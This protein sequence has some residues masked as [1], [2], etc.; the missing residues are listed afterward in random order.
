MA[1]TAQASVGISSAS[2]TDLA[3]IR[4]RTEALAS[5]KLPFGLDTETGYHGEDREGA[6]LHPEENF[7]V[8][9]QLTNDLSWAR[10]I[11]L[12]FDTGVN[13]D[14][15]AAAA[16]LWPLFHAI[17]DEGLP[18]AVAHG[19]QAELRWMSRWF[20]RNLWDHPLFGRQVIAAR[21]YYPVRSCTLL[22]SFTEGVNKSQALKSLTL[23]CYGYQMRELSDL[24]AAM[25]GRPPTDKEKKSVRFNVFDPS[26]PEVVAYAC[27]DAVFTLR[28]HKDRWPKVRNTFAYKVEMAVLP[29]VCDTADTGITYDWNMLR[30]AAAEIREFAG[31][32]LAEVVE[33][34][35]ALAGEKLP[36][37]FN[38]GSSMQLCDLFYEKCKLPVYHWTD[39]GKS[40][41]KKPSIDAKKALPRL[42]AEVPEVAKYHEW[43]RLNT[44]HDNFLSIYEAKYSWSADGKAHPLLVQH[45]TIAGR[46]SCENPNAQQPPGKYHVTLRDGTEFRFN[47]RDAI[48]ASPAG[49]R[50]W[51]ELVLIDAGWQ[52]PED[53][54]E[55]GWYIEG[56]DY[57]QIELRVLAAEA[58]E[59]ALLEAFERGEDVHRLT[60][61][62]MLGIPLAEV[63]DE[64][65]QDPGKRMNFAIGYGLSPH[66]LAQ[67]TGMS[68]AAA[69]EKFAAFHAAYPHLKPFTRRVVTR[70]RRDGCVRT[71]F[72]RLVTLHD[73]RNENPRVRSAEERTAGNCVIQGPATGDYVKMA[74]VRAVRALKAAGLADKVRLI[75][76]IHDA[77]EF[78]VRRD[79]APADVI[80]VLEPAVIFPI[81]GPGVPWPP[82]VADWHIGESWGQKRE[83]HMEAGAVVLGKREKCERCAAP[84]PVPVPAPE[85][86]SP[87]ASVPPAAPAPEPVPADPDAPPRRVIVETREMPTVDQVARLAEF[88]RSLPGPNSVELQVPDAV[89]Q[90]GFP[91]GLT[92]AH[93]AQVAVILGSSVV[94]YDLDSVD[95]GALVAGLAL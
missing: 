95:A 74:M 71:K 25:L 12:G 83:L 79:V 29:I 10:M 47:W 24:Q 77:L 94:H 67:Q 7:I 11:P 60:A 27:E 87:A 38:F 51:W 84:P 4:E 68:T 82:L 81:T 53:P 90:V 28:H 91:C 56:Y 70:A 43:K 1:P 88:L 37:D 76:N 49:Q 45:G 21:G 44:L 20:L 46:F 62:R 14:N 58:G 64:Q 15:K 65:R 72:G 85:P 35:E 66:G 9:V 30:A 48:I 26:D 73:I 16:L 86:S 80:A 61:A 18:L 33:D 8:S 19:A 69:E 89:H 39:G 6:A 52:P 54:D 40:G 93:E 42:I 3:E 92:P 34:F 31:R 23:A 63:T 57:S 59:T 75:M 17:D 2:L 36:P 78:E 5:A 32:L 41:V 22:E 50:T 55:L 13:V